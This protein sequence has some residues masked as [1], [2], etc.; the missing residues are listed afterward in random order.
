MCSLF[1]IYANRSSTDG[2]NISEKRNQKK[3]DKTKFETAKRKEER[4]SLQSNSLDP[5]LPISAL[6]QL[7]CRPSA[8]G[9]NAAFLLDSGTRRNVLKVRVVAAV[10]HRVQSRC[11]QK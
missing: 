8:F 10:M 1:I 3:K 9:V 5:S 2:F 11:L 6:Q 4:E 7:S